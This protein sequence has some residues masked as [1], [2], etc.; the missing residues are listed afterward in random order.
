MN[1]DAFEDWLTSYEDAWE[2]RDGAAAGQ[3][4]TEDAEYHQTPFTVLEGREVIESYWEHTTAKQE[5]IEVVTEVLGTDGDRGFAHFHATYKS[6][7]E[8]DEPPSG[9][10]PDEVA[11]RLDGCCV[12]TLEDEKCSVFREWW[13]RIPG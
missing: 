3:L 6:P 10:D 12:V 2:S 7:D 11:I 1:R 4:F 5:D 9:F 8:I 13:H